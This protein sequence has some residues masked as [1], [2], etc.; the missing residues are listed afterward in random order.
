MKKLIILLLLFFVSCAESESVEP[1]STPVEEETI[2]TMAT[3]HPAKFIDAM[4]S[5]LPDYQVKE[6]SQLKPSKEREEVFTVLPNDLKVVKDYVR[7][8]LK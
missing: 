8:N 2:V 6:P 4:K 7:M 1:V 3:A 5:A